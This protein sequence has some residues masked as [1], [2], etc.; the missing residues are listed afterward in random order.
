MT[1]LDKNKGFFKK[2]FLSNIIYEENY[3]FIIFYTLLIATIL[4]A[5]SGYLFLKFNNIKPIEINYSD[6]C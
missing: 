5:L 3:F 1:K 2:Y 6:Y 4:V